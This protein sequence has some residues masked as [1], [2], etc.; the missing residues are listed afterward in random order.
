M[1]I[2]K[3]KLIEDLADLQGL[4][5]TAAAESVDSFLN[6]ILGAAASGH[7]V[8][9]QGFGTF[10]MKTRAARTARNPATGLPVEVPA[11]TALTFKPAKAKA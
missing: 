1:A 8:I 3:G 11:K 9:L 6:L 2:S 10:E 5:K 7:K 4:T